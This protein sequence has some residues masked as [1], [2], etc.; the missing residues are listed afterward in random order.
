M[1]TSLLISD[2]VYQETRRRAVETHRTIGEVVET[3]LRNWLDEEQRPAA[4]T[5]RWKPVQGL[6][7]SGVNVDDRDALYDVLDGRR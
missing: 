7:A 6:R 2:A 1:K 3:A 5:W 4:Y